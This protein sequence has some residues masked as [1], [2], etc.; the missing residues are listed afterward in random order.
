MA[1]KLYRS[2]WR[3]ASYSELIRTAAA[4]FITA[5]FHTVGI[6]VLFGRMPISY[7]FIGA[8]VQFGF[9]IS[10]RFAYRFMLLVRR[11]RRSEEE[12]KNVMIIGAGSAGQMILRDVNRA[13]QF[14][15]RVVCIID[16]NV[17][18]WGRYI[19]GTPIVGGRE[20]ILENVEKYN[21]SKIYIAVPSA[22]MEE[23]REIL[24]ICKET[25]CEL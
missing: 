8:V 11:E 23:R 1:L 4:S 19:D 7:Y 12:T 24:N 6:T 14:S 10:I 9:V 5:V 16:D 17:N 20:S 13:K 18:K 25:E 2:M 22:P 21:I 15:D 3:F